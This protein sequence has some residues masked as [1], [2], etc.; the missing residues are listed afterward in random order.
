[1]ILKLTGDINE[2]MLDKVIE[3][4]NDLPEDG[5][6]YIYLRSRGGDFLFMQPI[7]NIIN[8]KANNTRLIGFCELGSCAFELFFRAACKKYLLNG[9]IGMYHQSTFPIETNERNKPHDAEDKI[10]YD[11]MENFARNNTMSLCDDLHFTK[12]EI[13][14]I[15]EGVDYWFSVDRMNEFMK[16]V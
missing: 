16:I 7:L 9:C 13:E 3:A 14:R 2:E 15:D 6:L 12:Y 11:Y 10:R 4:Y 5:I 1:M 8:L